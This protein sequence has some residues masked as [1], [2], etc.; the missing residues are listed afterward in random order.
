MYRVNLG[1]IFRPKGA[2]TMISEKLGALPWLEWMFELP[3]PY[4]AGLYLTWGVLLVASI[5]IDNRFPKIH[6]QYPSVKYGDLGL[7]AA[8]FALLLA[9]D[10]VVPAG[11]H[12]YQ[13]IWYHVLLLVVGAAGAIKL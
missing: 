1:T 3:F 13:A 5:L 2:P 10:Y 4:A 9:V 8:V 6:K 11:Q 7:A 12:W